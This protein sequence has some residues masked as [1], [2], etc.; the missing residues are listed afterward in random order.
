MYVVDPG[1]LVIIPA[2]TPHWNWNEGTEDELH[3]ELIVPAP[4]AGT[5]IVTQISGEPGPVTPPADGATGSGSNFEVVRRLDESRF[6]RNAFS[7]VVL[8]D[9]S[10][11]LHTVSLGVFRVPA[12]AQGPM[13]HMH[14]F[15]Q[16]YYQVSGSMQLELGFERYTVAPHTLVIIPAG[17]PHRNW[18]ASPSEPEYH[19]NL[20]VPEPASG[21]NAWDVPVTLGAA[22]GPA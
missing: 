7:Q 10:T 12:G 16:I 21:D 20:R 18:N 8:A 3:F 11:G 15:D 9:R 1:N 13:L 17:M 19:L 4:P 2:G 6:D 14:R 5:P 22:W